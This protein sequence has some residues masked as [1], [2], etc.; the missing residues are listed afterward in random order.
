MSRAAL[1]STGVKPADVQVGS[2]RLQGFFM[3]WMLGNRTNPT[4]QTE[5]CSNA[6]E[7]NVIKARYRNI[8]TDHNSCE[9]RDGLLLV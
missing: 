7:L 1:N 3:H 9:N 4:L 6:A 2:V 8:C 5:C